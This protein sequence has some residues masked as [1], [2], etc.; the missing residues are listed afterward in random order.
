MTSSQSDN[1]CALT[2][3]NTVIWHLVQLPVKMQEMSTDMPL[4]LLEHSL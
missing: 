3:F 4:T 1:Q 2:I